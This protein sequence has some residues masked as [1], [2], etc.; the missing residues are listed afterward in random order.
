MSPETVSKE[1][2]ATMAKRSNYQQRI[3]KNYYENKDAIMLQRLGE[4]VTDLYLAEGKARERLWTRIT[5]SLE[6][7]KIPADRIA[8][9]VKSDNPTL[10]ANL[11]TELLEAKP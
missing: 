4:L 11:L 6:K 2:P 3:I 1:S 7:L 8:K 10:L 9:I 5:T